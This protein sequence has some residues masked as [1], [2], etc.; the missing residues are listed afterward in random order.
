MKPTDKRNI[1]I[2][3]VSS[4]RKLAYR[5]D[6]LVDDFGW[7]PE[8]EI[9]SV[10]YEPNNADFLVEKL[11]SKKTAQKLPASPHKP[12]CGGAKAYRWLGIRWVGIPDPL[13]ERTFRKTPLRYL[14]Y[15]PFR[16]VGGL[17]P[18]DS[19]EG[20]AGCGCIL[21]LKTAYVVVK[22]GIR[23]IWRA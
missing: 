23:M 7:Y 15:T 17:H 20:Y 11:R 3:W 5:Q 19:E 21:K 12:T 4:N 2:G 8:G 14:A 9:F 16:L 10:P 22:Q 18:P 1:M 13:R 6:F